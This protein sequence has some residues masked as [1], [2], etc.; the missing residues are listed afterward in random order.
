MNVIFILS[1]VGTCTFS[2][3]SQLSIYQGSWSQK[4]NF[5]M[6]VV[7]ENKRWNENKNKKYIQTIFLISEVFSDISVQDI[8]RWM[9]YI[10][11]KDN[12]YAKLGTPL[13][14]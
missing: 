7:W 1:P 13:K 4:I 3:C 14:K 2:T 12:A 9:C 10:I 11:S 6:S 8:K 5:E